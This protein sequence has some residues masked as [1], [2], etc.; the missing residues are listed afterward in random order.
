MY[1]YRTWKDEYMPPFHPLY[2]TSPQLLLKSSFAH[3]HEFHELS[4]RLIYELPTPF[5]TFTMLK[6]FLTLAPLL[7][8]F[9]LRL[10]Q[11]TRFLPNNSL[12]LSTP[13]TPT[14][15]LTP[16]PSHI[17]PNL[18]VGSRNTSQPNGSLSQTLAAKR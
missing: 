6:P 3:P 13:T 15:P 10:L 17:E 5:P 18:P 7:L 11:I 14:I 2:N 16:L 1:Y 9:P 4:P 12:S 8:T